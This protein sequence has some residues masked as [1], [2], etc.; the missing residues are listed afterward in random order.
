[1]PLLISP[2]LLAISA[3]TLRRGLTWNGI[4][5]I[6]QRI[7]N[8]A[9]TGREKVQWDATMDVGLEPFVEHCTRRLN[10]LTGSG[11]CLSGQRY[12]DIFCRQSGTK[13]QPLQQKRVYLRRGGG[14]GA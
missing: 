7:V 10:F 2:S 13:T 8:F 9:S 12:A 6:G 11:F 5:R 14:V 4:C 1:M 3:E